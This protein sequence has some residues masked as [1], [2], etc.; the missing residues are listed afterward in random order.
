MGG[1]EYLQCMAGVLVC[2]LAVSSASQTDFNSTTHLVLYVDTHA[3]MHAR[4]HR[5]YGFH[6]AI[7]AHA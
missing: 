1:C 2:T 3:H 5:V 4:T 7:N 6:S